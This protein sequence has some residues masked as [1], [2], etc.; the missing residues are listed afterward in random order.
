MRDVKNA[1]LWMA[2][3]LLLLGALAYVML[4]PSRTVQRPTVIATSGPLGP[5]G[6]VTEARLPGASSDALPSVEWMMEGQNPGR[7][8]AVAAPLPL[9][10]TRQRA[11]G[12]ATD[13]EAGSPPVF[14]GGLMLVE[15]KD[16]LRAYDLRDG[17]QRWAYEHPGSY[18]SPTVAGDKVYIR[19]ESGNQ[20]QLVALDLASGALAWHFVPRRLSSSA[21]GY[22][23]GHLSAPVVVDGTLYVGAGKEVYALDAATG[24]QRWEFTAQELITSSAAVAGE[25]LFIS[26]FE[27]IYALDRAS[28]AQVWTSPSESAISFAPVVAEGTVLVTRGDGVAA[29][30]LVSGASRWELKIPGESLVAAGIAGGRAYVKS[31]ETLFA[32]SLADGTEAWRFKNLNF[33]SL[34]AVAGEQVFI[35]SGSGADSA[36]E[37]LDAASGASLY[38]Q[39]V[40]QLA[41]T[42]PVIAGRAIYLR[43]EDGRVL[44]LWS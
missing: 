44:G 35:V 4:Q 22:F 43:M 16:H 37:A 13:H 20:G 10:L 42:A 5:A 39:P 21:S 25:Q 1:G 19:V 38:R 32:L 9:P 40:R 6:P 3:T 17:S 30:D 36:L 28:G 11:V 24:E 12:V 27:F 33:V 34:P 29:L 2:A 23:G 26:D 41:T 14:A 31:T 15:T 18:I 8:R 7:T